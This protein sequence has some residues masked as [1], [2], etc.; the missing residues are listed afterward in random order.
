MSLVIKNLTKRFDSKQLF[1]DFSYSFE[2]TGIY[3][4]VGESGI[5]KTTLLRM[6]GGL[7]TDYSG[8]IIFDG[9]RRVS[10]AFQEHRLFPTLSALDNVV[11]AISNGKD[12]AVYEKSRKMLVA[13]GFSE[14]DM[15]LTPDALSGGMRQR[16]SV[17]RALLYK[18]DILLLDEP[19]KELDEENR[20]RLLSLIK[21]EGESR[22]VIIVS[23]DQNDLDRLG[24]TGII[25]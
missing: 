2:D 9:K 23:H 22:L 5:G 25:I 13:L 18:A 1:S 3:A 19:T 20:G 7:D 8:E 24:A 21:S 14:A 10:M 17:A 4:L 16:V 15:C 12:E 6:I 11:L